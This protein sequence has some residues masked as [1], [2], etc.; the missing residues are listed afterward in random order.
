[1]AR[2]WNAAK[3]ARAEQQAQALGDIQTFVVRSPL[4][5]VMCVAGFFAF[6]YGAV[7][8]VETTV[9]ALL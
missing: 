8:F 9:A 6:M 3:I 2:K 7:W 5:P 1:M 4:F